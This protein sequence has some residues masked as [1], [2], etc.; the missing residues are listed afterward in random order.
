MYCLITVSAID[1]EERTCP[2]TWAEEIK[3]TTTEERIIEAQMSAIE[4][5]NRIYS[6]T[7]CN[8]FIVDFYFESSQ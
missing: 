6:G 4:K 7:E 3:K 2:V 5:W 8:R 1:N